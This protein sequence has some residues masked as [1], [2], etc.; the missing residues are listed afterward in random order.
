[1]FNPN[2]YTSGVYDDVVDLSPFKFD[3]TEDNDFPPPFIKFSENILTNPCKGFS[4]LDASSDSCSSQ[5]VSTPEAGNDSDSNHSI[6]E[7]SNVLTSDSEKELGT[8]ITA[9]RRRSWKSFRRTL[10]VN[11]PIAP[12]DSLEAIQEQPPQPF[13]CR[14][15]ATKRSATNRIP[16]VAQ[17]KSPRRQPSTPFI[18]PGSDLDADGES[19]DGESGDEYIPPPDLDIQTT[20]NLKRRRSRS[21]YRRTESSP[22]PSLPLNSTYSSHSTAKRV[23]LAP[24]SRNKQASQA[25]SMAIIRAVNNNLVEQSNFICPECGWRQINKRVPDFKRHLKT[26]L[27]KDDNH[28]SGFW[29]K[30]VRV[31][32]ARKHTIQPDATPYTFLDHERIGG[33]M[34]TFSR[35]DALKRHLDNAN[36][37][38]VAD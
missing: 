14:S 30:G 22:R 23:R 4:P 36:I 13:R 25:T 7:K 35:R 37:F 19:D 28:S 38:C 6:Y 3:D 21:L 33:C 18:S 1:M 24:L 15:S 20:G 27:R 2:D 8:S 12:E 5:S 32:D 11:L 10:P 31:E 34:R 17:S 9:A 29:C 26:H 16:V